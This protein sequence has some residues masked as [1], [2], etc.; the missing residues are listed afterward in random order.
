MVNFNFVRGDGSWVGFAEVAR[1][2]ALEKLHLRTGCF[3]NV[4]CCHDALGISLEQLQANI[5]RGYACGNDRDLVDGRPTGSVRISFGYMSTKGD[6]DFFLGFVRRHFVEREPSRPE[7]ARLLRP[8]MLPVMGCN[9][10]IEA[11]NLAPAPETLQQPVLA[12]IC[13]FPIKSCAPFSP[14]SWELGPQ[15]LK[16]DREWMIIN[17]FNACVSQKQVRAF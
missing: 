10:I 9:A 11:P 13:V 7:L 16:F 14:E 17:R 5:S 8:L 15:G 3:C 4:G 6:A 12:A 2:A 1:M